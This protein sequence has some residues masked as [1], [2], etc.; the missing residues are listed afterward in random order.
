MYTY[1]WVHIM[2]VFLWLGY[3][4]QDDIFQFHPFAYEFHKD[5]ENTKKKEVHMDIHYT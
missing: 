2:F 1:Q 4:T 3:L 5:G